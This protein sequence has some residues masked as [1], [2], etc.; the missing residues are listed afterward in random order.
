MKP[1]P[2]YIPQLIEAERN[3][4]RLMKQQDRTLRRIENARARI[5]LKRLF[6]KERKL[7]WKDKDYHKEYTKMWYENLKREYVAMLGNKCSRC[8]Y[9]KYIG[10]LEFHH[11]NREDK[12]DNK[13]CTT[14]GFKQKILEGKIQLLCAN[15]HAEI[16]A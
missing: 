4:E 15:C 16:H 6:P 1:K 10:A 12:E 5:S 14:K 8:G 2:I 9:D 7:C 11:I 3:G 13:E